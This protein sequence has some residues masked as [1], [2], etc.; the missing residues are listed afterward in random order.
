MVIMEGSGLGK[1]QEHEHLRY[2]QNFYRAFEIYHLK[3]ACTQQSSRILPQSVC[4]EPKFV[5][6]AFPLSL[7]T[8]PEKYITL[9]AHTLPRLTKTVQLISDK[10]N[11][12]IRPG[13]YILLTEWYYVLVCR[14]LGK[15]DKPSREGRPP[16]SKDRVLLE[17]L[18]WVR[19]SRGDDVPNGEK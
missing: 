17:V 15:V 18:A 19:F 10:T 1:K 12:K 4:M 8:S 2:F 6:V 5:C 3:N 7:W 16:V 14:H 9:S 11:N 13:L